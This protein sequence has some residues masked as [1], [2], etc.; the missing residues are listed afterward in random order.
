MKHEVIQHTPEFHPIRITLTAE[1]QQEAELLSGMFNF[2]PIVDSLGTLGAEIHEVVQGFAAVGIRTNR[3]AEIA[4]AFTQTDW[5]KAQ[6]E[7]R[8]P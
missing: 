8:Q 5:F 1:T 7:T 4:R 3:T 2:A 6:I